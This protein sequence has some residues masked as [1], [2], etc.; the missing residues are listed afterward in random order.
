MV[1]TPVNLLVWDLTLDHSNWIIG[2]PLL[3]VTTSMWAGYYYCY[4]LPDI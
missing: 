4:Y 2:F 1:Y 3:D